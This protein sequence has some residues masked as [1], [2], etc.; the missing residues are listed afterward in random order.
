[1]RQCAMHRSAGPEAIGDGVEPCLEDRLQD[2]LHRGLDDSVFD[3]RNAQ[4]P[5]RTWFARLGDEHSS[6]RA[7]A[8]RSGPDILSDCHE[9]LLYPLVNW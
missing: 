1:M 3:G 6:H 2:V 9:E 4:G 5:E 7:R 8:K